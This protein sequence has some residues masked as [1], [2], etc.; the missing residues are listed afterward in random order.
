MDRKRKRSPDEVH[1]KHPLGIVGGKSRNENK[2]ALA[3]VTRSYDGLKVTTARR[4]AVSGLSRGS[5]WLLWARIALVAL[6]SR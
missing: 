1:P 5:G 4:S 6:R 3:T 2:E